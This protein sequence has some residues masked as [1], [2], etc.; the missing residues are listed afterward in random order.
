MTT[1]PA[2][3]A[4]CYTTAE[5]AGDSADD[6]VR[7][8]NNFTQRVPP[9]FT[10]LRTI[11]GAPQNLEITRVEG[12]SGDQITLF[13]IVSGVINDCSQVS[14]SAATLDKSVTYTLN[15]DNP[16]SVSLHTDIAA[17]NWS[18]CFRPPTGLWT[19][20]AGLTLLLIPQPTFV[21]RVWH[22]W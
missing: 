21:P 16:T 2:T 19:Y 6:W 8:V 20:V 7:L 14:D 22:C 4:V 18:L 1:A 9:T 3:L 12:N 11:V 5:S 13:R 17:G 15:Q 10:P